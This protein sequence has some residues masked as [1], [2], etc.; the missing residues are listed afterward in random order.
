MQISLFFWFLD[1]YRPVR[2]DNITRARHVVFPIIAFRYGVPLCY[3]SVKSNARKIDAISKSI[4]A[5]VRHTVGNCHTRKPRTTEGIIADTRNA[6]R[7]C[8]AR[9]TGAKQKGIIINARHTAVRRNDACITTQN[10]SFR[11]RFNKAVA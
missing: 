7:Y 3:R 10:Q 5:Y 2:A 11:C 6:V 4:C 8:D 1:I 9:Q